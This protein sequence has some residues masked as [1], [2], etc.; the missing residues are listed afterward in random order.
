VSLRLPPHRV[1]V[2]V[3]ILAALIRSAPAGAKFGAG[4]A[5]APVPVPT[6]PPPADP[7]LEPGFPV[8]TLHSGGTYHGGPAIH[9]LVGNLDTDPQLEIVVSGTGSGP[10]YAWNHDGSPVPGWPVAVGGVAYGAMGELA[11]E[12]D[13]LEVFAGI[14]TGSLGA[15][16]GE[17]TDLLGWPQAG[18][19]YITSPPALADVDGDGIDEIFIAQED[20]SLHGFE[21]DG[22][23]LTGWPVRVS[24]GS[25][26]LHVPAI[27][28]LDLDGRNEIVVTGDFWNGYAGYYNKVWV[29]D[30]GNGPHG[31]IAWGQ[32]MGGS[33]HQGFLAAL[34][35]GSTGNFHTVSPCRLVDTRG[36]VGAFGGPALAAGRDRSFTLVSRCGIP[37]G[38]RAVALNVTV[39]APS[40]TGNLVL[41]PSAA[42]AP[43]TSTVN[44]VSG[45][46]RANNAIIPIDASGRLW[47]RCRQGW[48]TAHLVLDVVGFFD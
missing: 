14:W 11:A 22:T 46:T 44:Y 34:G 47:V 24:Q 13:G 45:L 37:L 7:G 35:G 10:L 42:A 21:A 2:A 31:E 19:N 48:G 1:L 39:V 32:L 36:P 4:P 41:Y 12:F 9:T 20:W 30:L 26:S 6:P 43:P 16:S 27:A 38:A 29:Y 40:T 15:W 3:A 17:G 5:E 18:A 8:S 23:P 25:Q 28:D 33:R